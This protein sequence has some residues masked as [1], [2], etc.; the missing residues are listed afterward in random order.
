MERTIIKV[1]GTSCCSLAREATRKYTLYGAAALRHRAR[2]RA[3]PSCNR[4]GWS[5]AFTP[6][7]RDW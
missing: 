2:A 5:E 7:E 6:S 1:Y 3:H 4:T